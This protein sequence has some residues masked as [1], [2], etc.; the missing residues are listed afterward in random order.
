M[1]TN[2]LFRDLKSFL[3]YLAVWLLIMFLY[4]SLIYWGLQIPLV[5]SIAD[6]LIFN[7]VLAALGLGFWYPAKFILFDKNRFSIFLF[8]HLT[9]GIIAVLIWLLSGYLLTSAVLDDAQLYDDFFYSTL[10]WRALTGILIYFLAVSFYYVIIYYSEFQEKKTRESEL[11]SLITE[12]EL[13]SL[14]FQIN[15]HF[16]FNS[17]NSISS[18][19][20]I[21]PERAR[22]MIIKLADFL[23][24]TVSNNSRQM[25]TLEEELKNIRLYLDIEK[26]RF[27]DKFEYLESVDDSCR[28]SAVPNMILQ[29]LIENA[30]K[31]AVYEA[32][33]KIKIKV[34]CSAEHEY[35]KIEV[36]NT[37]EKDSDKPGSGVGLKNIS[38]RLQ[39]IYNR[40]DLFSIIKE[41]GEFKVQLYIPLALYLR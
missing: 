2:P 38:E 24:Y 21:E 10:A 19:T 23:R 34:N 29:P 31:H 12:A 40:N 41:D 18:L 37:L 4:F 15:P 32:L 25:N 13:K 35:L 9:A 30:V 22:L 6:S 5:M 1:H 17:L 20:V 39:L 36:M 3:L 11:K 26:I 8:T 28:V 27:E 14:K 33:E 16:I 7:L